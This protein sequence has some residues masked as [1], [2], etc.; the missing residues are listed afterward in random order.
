MSACWL[1]TGGAGFIGSNFVRLVIA[2]RPD[3]AVVNFD[4]LTYS[5][6]RENLADLEA[7]PRYLFLQG[8]V[9]EPVQ[10][11]TAMAA[12]RP[13]AIIHFAAESHVD[14]SIHS[15]EA[16]IR[17]N[18]QGTQ[19][20]LDAARRQGVRRFL[21]VSTDEVYG[22][23]GAEGRFNEDSP[24]LPNSPY[25]ASKAAS[26]VL[27]RAA[28]QTH[29]LPAIITRA[30]N[31]YGPYQFPEKLIPLAIANAEAGE[32]IP[33]Y[34]TGDN[35]RNWIH[36]SDHCRGVLA[37]LEKGQP[38]AVYNL[39]GDDELA[40]RQLLEKLLAMLGK[41]LSLIRPVAD[42]PGHDHRYALDS[43]QARRELGWAPRVDFEAGLRQT[44]EWYRDH[45]A[46]LAEV[47]GRH[48]QDYYQRQYG[49]S[50]TSS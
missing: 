40:N 36:V 32:P 48:Y 6:R 47:R 5:G 34:G 28:V 49:A 20:L 42:R 3:L 16:F 13:E 44:V 25:A 27:V 17:T 21:H 35:V 22:S 23:L 9:A 18:V 30:S 31:N 15:A 41:P 29:A 45:G 50:L 7:N 10:V 38:G 43:S 24:L 2:E 39:G 1:V 33:L 19:V 46:W 8:D 37:A 4:A 14:R 12:H 11:E 26:D